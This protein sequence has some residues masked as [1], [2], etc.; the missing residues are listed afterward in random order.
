MTVPRAGCSPA[1][2]DCVSICTRTRACTRTLTSAAGLQVNSFDSCPLHL[3]QPS[4]LFSSLLCPRQVFTLYARLAPAAGTSCPE[5]LHT[6]ISTSLLNCQHFITS[7]HQF[8]LP[9]RPTL[10]LPLPSNSHLVM[11]LMSGL[12]IHEGRGEVLASARALSRE[13]SLLRVDSTE[14]GRGVAARK[15][16]SR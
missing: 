6:C 4:T 14:R 9:C 3:S 8:P 12:H 10:F 16:R 11:H 13:S 7:Q 15:R 5:I 2:C 1:G